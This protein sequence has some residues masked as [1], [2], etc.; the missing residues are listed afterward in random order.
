VR[1]AAGIRR[2]L[3]SCPRSFRGRR[4]GGRSRLLVFFFCSRE[5]LTNDTSEL[6]MSCCGS[7]VLYRG[8]G[9]SLV[10]F[11]HSAGR[12]PFQVTPNWDLL[13]VE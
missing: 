3:N 7:P 13:I 5:T 11:G 10:V 2:M 8:H 1:T 9:M 4:N 12:F 6:G